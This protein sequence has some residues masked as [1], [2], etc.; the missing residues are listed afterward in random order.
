METTRL[1]SKGQV[2]IPKSFRDANKWDA[3]TEFAVIDTAEGLLLK[4]RASFAPSV[5]AEVAGIFRAKVKRKSDAEIAAALKRDM[6]RKW[7]A[8]G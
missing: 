5:L 6:R 7:R 4:P 8:R 3:G 2:V 1:S